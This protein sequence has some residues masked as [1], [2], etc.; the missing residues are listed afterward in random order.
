[1]NDDPK[2]TEPFAQKSESFTTTCP[3]LETEAT[4]CPSRGD[5]IELRVADRCYRISGSVFGTRPQLDGRAK[6][7]LRLWL[8]QQ[9]ESGNESPLITDSVIRSSLAATDATL[10]VDIS[11]SGATYYEVTIDD[12][13]VEFNSNTGTAHV[14]ANTW[15][16]LAWIVSGTPGARYSIALS[17][18]NGLLDIDKNP[19]D[20]PIDKSGKSTGHIQFSVV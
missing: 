16:T 1:M 13:P 8:R 19:I 20:N 6:S 3:L 15:L 2:W 18:R 4:R 9:W 12:A 14:Q 11:V 7:R 17:A 5:Y 10:R